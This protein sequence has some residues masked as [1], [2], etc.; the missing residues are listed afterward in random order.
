MSRPVTF[1]FQS[2][3]GETA[4]DPGTLGGALPRKA[5]VFRIF[6]LRDNL[7]LLDK[8][9]NLAERIER[10]YVDERESRALDLRK[11]TGR[12]EYCRTD[13]PFETLYL[14]H[15]ERRV[16]FPNTYHRMR[17]FPRAYLLKINLRQRF[18]RIY[19]TRQV[20]HGVR[21]FGPFPSR[22]QLDRMKTTLE[23]TFKLRPCEYNIRG[24]EPYPD[25]LYYQMRTCSRPCA[26]DIGR[27]D[28]LADVHAAIAFLEGRDDA[29][30]TRLVETMK[31]LADQTR[32]EEAENVRRQL[33]RVERG[34]RDHPHAY[35]DL[36]RFDFL[37][38]MRSDSARRRK[39][40]F[41]R[42][43]LVVAIE[44]H[45]VAGLG[46]SLDASLNALDPESDAGDSSPNRYDDFCLVSHFIARPVRTVDIVPIDG[47]V[48]ET[49]V[50]NVERDRKVGARRRPGSRVEDDA[51]R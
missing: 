17:T 33:D 39:V 35:V 37:V 43:G 46:T 23:R 3:P 30:R 7:I 27:E 48:V 44:E 2:I 14:L 21:Y 5:G 18:P 40:A 42:Q 1:A 22:A 4:L 25:C 9:H 38:V 19:A 16:W 41:V 31:R 8:T 51:P 20:K 47:D 49:V 12:I 26:G 24:H 11:I 6:D 10:F 50:G 36:W 34:R 45:E 29:I 15:A 32:F 28:Y 13:S